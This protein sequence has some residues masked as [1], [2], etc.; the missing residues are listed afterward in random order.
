[1]AEE[2]KAV[3]KGEGNFFTNAL[4]KIKAIPWGQSMKPVVAWGVFGGAVALS[5]ILMLIFWL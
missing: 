3:T 5:V 2:K 4:A 1:M